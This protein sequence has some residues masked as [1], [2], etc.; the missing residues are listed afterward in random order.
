VIVKKASCDRYIVQWYGAASDAWRGAAPRQLYRELMPSR[1]MFGKGPKMMVRVLATSGIATGVAKTDAT[2]EAWKYTSPAVSLRGAPSV[3]DK[4]VPIE[5][6]I[7]AVATDMSGA[8]LD[9]SRATWYGNGG[10]ALARGRGSLC[11]RD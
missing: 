10:A 2:F 4:P 11:N 1:E 3:A 5:A 6:V 7:E 8:Q 9:D